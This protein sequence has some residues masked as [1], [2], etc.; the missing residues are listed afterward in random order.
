[1]ATQNQRTVTLY[2]TK[3]GSQKV[4]TDVSTWGELKPIVAGRYDLSNLQATESVGKTT[5]EHEDA[6]LPA[7]DFVLFLRPI[8]TKSGMASYEDYE[9]D[10][11]Y[12]DENYDGDSA[13]DHG[14]E[15]SRRDPLDG[16]HR[17]IIAALAHIRVAGKDW[18]DMGIE[19]FKAGL[20]YFREVEEAERETGLLFGEDFGLG[21]GPAETD[22]RSP[23]DQRLEEMLESLERGF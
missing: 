7:G 18:A 20:A 17:R 13:G 5:L 6:A 15:P 1:M 19:V 14:D 8:R 21:G 10:D 16:Q 4:Q 23:E 9:D 11:D 3:G 12:D 2:S 22:P